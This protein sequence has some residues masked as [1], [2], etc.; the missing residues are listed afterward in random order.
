MKSINKIIRISDSY[1]FD[2]LSFLS[3]HRFD[4]K[5]FEDDITFSEEINIPNV[6]T[7]LFVTPEEEKFFQKKLTSLKPNSKIRVTAPCVCFANCQNL[8]CP[9][10]KLVAKPN[11]PHGCTLLN[12]NCKEY[13]IDL[14][15]EYY[16]FETYKSKQQYCDSLGG[17]CAKCIFADY[18]VDGTNEYHITCMAITK[19]EM[20]SKLK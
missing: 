19:S 13:D 6:N 10:N 9:K 18:W 12:K 20:I 15:A 7:E 5:Q 4:L 17:D 14:G 2:D 16:N 8:S 1:S 3:I 11:S